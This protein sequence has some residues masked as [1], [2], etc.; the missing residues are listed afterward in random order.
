[1]KGRALIK[2]VTL[3]ALLVPLVGWAAGGEDIKL[4]HVNIDLRNKASLQRGAHIFMNYCSGCHSLRYTRYSQLAKDI[5]VVDED[6]EVLEDVVQSSLMF[7]D[8]SLQDPIAPS[9]APHDAAAWFGVTPPDL[10]LVARSRG[11][12]WIYTFLR[13]FYVDPSRP[14]GVNNAAFPDVGMPDVL[15]NLQGIQEAKFEGEGPHRHVASLSQTK[16]GMMSQAQF[17]SAMTDLVNFLVLVG[18]PHQLQRTHIG[19]W[20]LL[21]LLILTVLAYVLKKEYWKDVK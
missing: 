11:A 12:D 4:D 14:W 16:A 6:N 8:A 21:F 9:M 19:G 1:M 18:E 20:V 10:T 2:A 13:S 17:D 3:L 7:A 5:G 15:V